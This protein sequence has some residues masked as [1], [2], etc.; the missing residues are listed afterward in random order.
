MLFVSAYWS[1]AEALDQKLEHLDRILTALDGRLPIIIGVGTNS[2]SAEWF[3]HE[4]C[5]PGEEM[6]DHAAP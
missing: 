3:Y 6:G 4:T 5:P 1:P 2:H